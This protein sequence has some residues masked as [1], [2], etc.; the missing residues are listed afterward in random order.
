MLILVLIIDWFRL[1]CQPLIV[2]ILAAPTTCT[3]ATHWCVPCLSSWFKKLKIN[4]NV[5]KWAV[6][7]RKC[8]PSCTELAAS[9]HLEWT[10]TLCALCVCSPAPCLLAAPTV[11][12]C[13]QISSSSLPSKT[14]PPPVT[15]SINIKQ[16]RMDAPLC[17]QSHSLLTWQAVL[18][19]TCKM[20]PGLAIRCT[21]FVRKNSNAPIVSFVWIPVPCDSVAVQCL[22]HWRTLWYS[23]E[24]NNLLYIYKK[25][26]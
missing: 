24:M 11:R 20:P 12:L 21:F 3:K 9:P 26:L 14:K 1:I 22:L 17:K 6:D 25:K 7:K 8:L 19:L 16:W 18:L 10:L 13:M 2:R 5:D 4:E 23:W 15:V